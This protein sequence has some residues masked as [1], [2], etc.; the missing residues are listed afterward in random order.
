MHVGDT[1]SRTMVVA[2][3]QEV[4]EDLEAGGVVVDG[5]DAHAHRE[6]VLAAVPPADPP[7]HGHLPPR[8]LH[9]TAGSPNAPANGAGMGFAGSYKSKR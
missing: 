4:L 5:E 9:G 2:A 7:L 8:V 6:L 1:D 3:A